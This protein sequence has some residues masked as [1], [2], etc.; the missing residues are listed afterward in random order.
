[1]QQPTAPL[2]VDIELAPGEKLTLP[3][4]IVDNIGPGHWLITISPVGPGYENEVFRDHSAFLN[5]YE[6]DDEGLYDDF[7]SR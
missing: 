4:S 7:T 3:S 1:M 5:G 6:P 2:C